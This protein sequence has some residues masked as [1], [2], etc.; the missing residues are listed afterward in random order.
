VL[1]LRLL[2]QYRHRDKRLEYA[3]GDPHDPAGGIFMVHMMT[4]DLAVVATARDGWDHVSVSTKTKCPNWAQMEHIKRLFFKDTEAAMQL[5]VPVA[6]HINIHP[7]TLHLWRPWD[8]PIP[9]PPKDM[10]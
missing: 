2:S 9:L 10:V 4:A 1:D 8:V 7:H 3:Y 6:D 5:H